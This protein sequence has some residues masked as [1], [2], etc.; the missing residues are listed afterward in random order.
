MV[1]RGVQSTVVTD[2]AVF[3]MIS[4]VNMVIVGVHA[5]MVNGAVIAPVGMRMVA[6]AAHNYAI[7]LVVVAG[8]HKLCPL[9]PYNP[10]V[11]L[12]DMRCPSERV[13]FWKILQLHGFWNW[14]W[15]SSFSHRQFHI[16]LC[17]SRAHQSFH[18]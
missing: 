1:K 13:D 5:V 16:R 9:Y 10:G 7:P 15:C 14:Q 12:N 4:R 3:A 2:S 17:P 6:L 8:T 18:H 11:L